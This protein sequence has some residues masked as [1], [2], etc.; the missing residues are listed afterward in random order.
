MNLA[1]EHIDDLKRSG[2]SDE[3][4]ATCRFQSERYG[5]RITY[6]TLHGEVNGFNR[7]R[8]VPPI[9]DRDGRTRKYSQRKGSAPHLYL[10]PLLDWQTVAQ[11]PQRCLVVVE[12]EKKTC[13]GVQVGLGAV[14]VGGTWCWRIKL[15]SGVASG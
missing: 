7:W 5:Y 11:N 2:L 14:G 6:F 9:K 13:M 8:L 3:T 15:E 4:I 10:P 1:L 12:G